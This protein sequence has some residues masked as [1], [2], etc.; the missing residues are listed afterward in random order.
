MV[1][2]LGLGG[3]NCLPFPSGWGGYFP[4]SG[5]LQVQQ[6]IETRNGELWVCCPACK[7]GL[8]KIWSNTEVKHFP[9]FCR[10]CR[11]T[12]GELNI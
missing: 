7:L 12:F 11:K 9:V 10:K 8:H 3:P 4:G 5:G 1:R 2:Y 6:V